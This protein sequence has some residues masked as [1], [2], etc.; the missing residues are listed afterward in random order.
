[1]SMTHEWT[2][3]T[4]GSTQDA[5]QAEQRRRSAGANMINQNMMGHLSRQVLGANISHEVRKG[6][7]EQEE[8]S[9]DSTVTISGT[10]VNRMR[11][12]L[13]NYARAQNGGHMPPSQGYQPSW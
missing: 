2:Q 7:R 5:D 11:Q 10:D 6:N 8:R 9:K 13:D 4:G 3:L 12:D 1:M